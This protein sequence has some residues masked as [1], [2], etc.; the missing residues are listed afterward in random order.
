MPVRLRIDPTNSL[1]SPCI[2]FLFASAYRLPVV[3]KMQL[4]MHLATTVLTCLVLCSLGQRATQHLGDS[5]RCHRMPR[6]AVR[7]V[8]QCLRDK[9][10]AR[11]RALAQKLPLLLYVKTTEPASTSKEGSYAWGPNHLSTLLTL[12]FNLKSSS[13]SLSLNVLSLSLGY[14]Y[15][16]DSGF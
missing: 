13:S 2:R 5:L 8:C 9:P 3:A 12:D 16:L 14:S 1:S 10:S 6:L 7:V 11:R 15:L 4:L